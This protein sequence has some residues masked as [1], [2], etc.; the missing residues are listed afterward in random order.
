MLSSLRNYLFWVRL[1]EKCYGDEQA[2]NTCTY[3][4]S[5][6]MLQKV[7]NEQGTTKQQEYIVMNPVCI[8]LLLMYAYLVK[9]VRL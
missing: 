1:L 2:S 6:A 5:S 7:S 9:Y 3:I 4:T 8:L